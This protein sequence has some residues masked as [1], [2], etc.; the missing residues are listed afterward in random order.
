[1]NFNFN[2]WPDG[3]WVWFH[4]VCSDLENACNG[5]WYGKHIYWILCSKVV[6]TAHTYCYP[7]GED[8]F[9]SDFDTKFIKIFFFYLATRVVKI[10]VDFLLSVTFELETE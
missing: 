1:M 7:C 3:F 5:T 8:F 2:A 4:D 6:P 10:S 9:G